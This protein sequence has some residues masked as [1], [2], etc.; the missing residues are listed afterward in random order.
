MKTLPLAT[1][2]LPAPETV[3]VA[4]RIGT[5][6][7]KALRLKPADLK[8]QLAGGARH[9]AVEAVAAQA[10][11]GE[12]VVAAVERGEA[13][14]PAQRQVFQ[15]RRFQLGEQGVHLLAHFGHLADVR[16]CLLQ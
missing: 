11:F 9:A 15:H 8:D 4:E 16:P 12:A 13:V 1:V 5:A 6:L 7:A 2:T 10:E 3:V 14:R